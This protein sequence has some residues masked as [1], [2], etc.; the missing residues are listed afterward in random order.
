M[1]FRRISF[2]IITAIA[3]FTTCNTNQASSTKPL[4]HAAYIWQRKWTP[5]LDS[6]I[7]LSKGL[8]SSAHILAF[9]I[10]PTGHII[11]L[12]IDR[13]FL[14]NQTIPLTATIR[15]SDNIP[16]TVWDTLP[17]LIKG[18]STD[19]LL[20]WKG[21]EIDYDCPTTRLREYQRHLSKLHS[22]FPGNMSL[23]IT[24]L[25]TWITSK[26]LRK[27]TSTVDYSILQVHAIANPSLHLF[28]QYEASDYISEFARITATPF[29]VALPAYSVRIFMDSEDSLVG[30]ESE[31]PRDDLHGLA[32]R[33]VVTEPGE[34]AALI[35]R[36]QANWPKKVAGF[37]WFRLP[38]ESDIR[39][40]K[41]AVLR[42]VIKGEPLVSEACLIRSESNGTIDLSVA[43]RGNCDCALPTVEV[44]GNIQYAEALSGYI[45]VYTDSALLFRPVQSNVLRA[46]T[47]RVVGWL[48]GDSS[49]K[50]VLRRDSGEMLTKNK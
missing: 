19:S 24:I 13:S 43:N 32:G 40:W 25:P 41:P 14:K 8:F 4:P 42:A 26:S 36:V 30:V 21:V 1:L 44:R 34:V 11:R 2:I 17:G 39:S 16:E 28:N 35:T 46:G 10:E 31:S 45:S 50:C 48:R 12:V 7:A 27:L 37:I 23:S 47:R 38:L 33:E 6:A 3:A 9:Q 15:L 18:L 20:H 29:L 22:C 5:E 49:V